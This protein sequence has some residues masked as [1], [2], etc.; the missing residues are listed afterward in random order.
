LLR[1]AKRNFSNKNFFRK[2]ILLDIF[3]GLKDIRNVALF[4]RFIL[5]TFSFIPKSN[6]FL[7]KNI[8]LKIIVAVFSGCPKFYRILVYLYI[9]VGVYRLTVWYTFLRLL[10]IWY[11]I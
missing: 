10:G 11:K 6:F 5:A 4:L 3:K 1:S 8:E 2:K 9:V 7:K